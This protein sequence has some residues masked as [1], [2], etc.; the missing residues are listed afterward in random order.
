[1][2]VSNLLAPSF[3]GRAMRSFIFSSVFH[4][5][6]LLLVLVFAGRIFSLPAIH[7]ACKWIKSMRCRLWVWRRSVTT[8]NCR[9]PGHS[10]APVLHYRPRVEMRCPK[11]FFKRETVACFQ[12]FCNFLFFFLSFFFFF[13][14][15]GQHRSFGP[16]HICA[17][18][19]S[20]KEKYPT[21]FFTITLANIDPIFIT[22]S[23]NSEN[24]YSGSWN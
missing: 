5:L 19:M 6:E 20:Q 18:T 16:L 10:A 22:F 1:M 7:L 17:Y 21:L 11:I 3:L 2:L 8:T 24:N 9:G 13:L 4:I 14:G 23:L 12:L 15:G